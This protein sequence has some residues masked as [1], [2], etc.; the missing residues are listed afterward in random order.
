MVRISA[1]LIVRDEAA[2]LADC[3][4]SLVGNVDEIVLVDTGSR[5]DTVQIAERFPIKLHRF[6]WCDDFSAARNFALERASG[7]WVLAIDADERLEI[8]DRAA[9]PGLLSKSGKVGWEVLYYPRTGWT[10]YRKMRLFRNDSRIRYQGVIHEKIEPAAESVARSDGLEIGICDLR[11][12][13]VVDAAS[14]RAKI[15]RYLPLL[16]RQLAGDPENF[17]CWW[18]LGECLRLSG[19]N[20][21]AT[22]AWLAGIS[23]LR[24]IPP[25]CRKLG[26]SILYLSLIQLQHECGESTEALI[27][28]AFSDFPGHLTLQ[29]FTARLAAERGDLE[30]AQPV[31][32]KLMAID[33]D[34]FL[35]P[36]LSY[37]KALFHH[38]PAQTLALCH[39]RRGRFDEA[40]RLYRVAAKTAPDP[41]ACNV[42]ARLAELRRSA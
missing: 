41:N 39:F 32:E 14:P 16:R 19:D 23:R 25:E 26:D 9:F 28:Q 2:Y 35:E 40:A 12:V 21:G 27:T 15:S 7:D 42:K 36:Q 8:P 10:P 6:T 13:H 31:L 30:A 37:D 29:W 1:T 11:V 17:Y 20:E 5:D 24:D 3:L 34:T 38:L 33:A 18:H 22:D 4:R